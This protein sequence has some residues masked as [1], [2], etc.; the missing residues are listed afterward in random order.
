MK[1][2]EWRQVVTDY[3]SFS[4][5]E[6]WAVLV[7]LALIILL[8]VLPDYL[9]A[10]GDQPVV[11][12]SLVLT[13]IRRWDSVDQRRTVVR[14]SGPDAYRPTAIKSKRFPFDPNQIDMEQWLQLGLPEKT[15]HTILNYR[16]K[17]GRFRK[18]EDLARIYGMPAILA[19]ELIP[20]VRI[21]SVVGEKSPPAGPRNA[22]GTQ[23]AQRTESLKL[24]INSADSLAWMSLRGIGEKLAGRIVN[25]RN[26]LGGFYSLQQVG[27]VY[28][29]KDSVFQQIRSSLVLDPVPVRQLSLN[30]A[31]LE[32]LAA[33]PYIR[34]PI[35]RAIVAYRQEH[36]AFRSV[37]E[38]SAIHLISQEQLE[39]IRPYCKPD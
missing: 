27:E 12:D 2:Q 22:P 10:P 37:E 26:R 3:F 19:R 35:A 9:P 16:S 25:F 14:K 21:E 8:F 33:H 24:P 32:E 11:V 7:L 6:R 39:K 20:W 38:L 29:L 34:F 13:A 31:T 28:G 17:G 18:A 4:V 36:G 15:A 1:R 30:A 5:R 23:F